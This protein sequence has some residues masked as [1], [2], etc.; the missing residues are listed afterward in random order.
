MKKYKVGDN[1]WYVPNGKWNFQREATITAIGR[2]WL[3]F[4]DS[5]RA[6]IDGLRVD[7]GKYSPP[8]S[9]FECKSDYEEL[10]RLNSAWNDFARVIDGMYCFPTGMTIEKIAKMKTMLVE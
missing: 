1:F 10:R 8:G 9:L 5:M 3:H 7:G 4:G 6:E 2:K